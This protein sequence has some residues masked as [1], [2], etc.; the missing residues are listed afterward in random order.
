MQKI[1]KSTPQI[2]IPEKNLS[3]IECIPAGIYKRINPLSLDTFAGFP[4]IKHLKV[5]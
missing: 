4:S 1:D 2:T 3:I 5:G